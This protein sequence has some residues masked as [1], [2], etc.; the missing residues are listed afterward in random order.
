MRVSEIL[1]CLLAGG[2]LSC[3]ALMATILEHYHQKQQEFIPFLTGSGIIRALVEQ[4][5]NHLKMFKHINYLVY[6][7][8]MNNLGKKTSLVPCFNYI[9]CF[10]H[11]ILFQFLQNWDSSF[12]VLEV[13]L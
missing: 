4:D 2:C 8:Q 3:F 5:P 6:S 10:Q 12:E 11:L 13:E 9:Y 7:F 1:Y